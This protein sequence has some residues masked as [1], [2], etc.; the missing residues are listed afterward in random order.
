MAG[1][2]PFP[3]HLFF[4]KI[5]PVLPIIIERD[6]KLTKNDENDVLTCRAAMDYNILNILHSYFLLLKPLRGESFASMSVSFRRALPYAEYLEALR[7][8]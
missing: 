3:F 8:D 5:L 6:N 7:A 4:V 2:S 1:F